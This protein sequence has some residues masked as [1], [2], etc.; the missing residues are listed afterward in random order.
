MLSEFLDKATDETNR[1]LQER[2]NHKKFTEYWHAVASNMKANTGFN[3]Q[4]VCDIVRAV[5]RKQKGCREVNSVTVKFNVPRNCKTFK[6][7]GFNFVELGLYPGRRIAIPIRTNH[8]W[9]RFNGLLVSG[10]IWKCYG[11]TPT[12]DIAAYLFKEELPLVRRK[13]LLGVDV[14]CKSFALTVLS[15]EG[16]ARCRHYH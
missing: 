2:P 10:W 11:L 9:Q 8:N 1:I 4:V 3:I 15:P 13:N 7:K 14:N 6:T 12:L 5:W 16:K